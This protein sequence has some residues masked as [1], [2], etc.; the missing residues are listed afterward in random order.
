M[1]IIELEVGDWSNDGH[2]QSN[3]ISIR[4][5]LSPQQ[6]SESYSTGCLKV[7]FNFIEDYCVEYEDQQIPKKVL[8]SIPNFDCEVQQVDSYDDDNYSMYHDSWVNVYLL[9]CKLGNPDFEYELIK[10]ERIP[11]GGYGLYYN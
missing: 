10:G 5:N 11:I 1:F 6:V 8:E 9:I 7:G 2:N 3:V 4:S